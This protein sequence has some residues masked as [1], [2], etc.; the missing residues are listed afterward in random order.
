[1]A[2]FLTSGSLSQTVDD[3]IAWLTEWHRL[4]FLDLAPRAA[5]AKALTAPE[6]FTIWYKSALTALP[7]DQPSIDRLAVLHDQ[8]HTF[9]RLVLMKTPDGTPVARNDYESVAVKFEEFMQGLRRLERAFS[10]AASGLDLLTGLRSRVGL[11]DDLA[12][13]QSR[14]V[15]NG[16][17]YCVAM[18]DI[19]HFKSINDTYGHDAGDRVLAAVAD[20]VSRSLRPFDDAYRVGGEE[21]LFCLKEADLA[22]GLKVLERLRSGLEKMTIT[23]GGGPSISVTASFGLTVSVKEVSTEDLLHRADQALYRAK[24]TGR[25]K[26]VVLEDQP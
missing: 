3:H 2:S 25:N 19:D 5:Q 20:H 12:K 13:E 11:Q 22:A 7:Q 8:L 4:A 16:K 21:F 15:R 17:P 6:N 10:V 26:I 23:L 9:A 14:F 1:M 24:N 18:M